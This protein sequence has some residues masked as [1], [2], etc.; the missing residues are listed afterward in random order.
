VEDDGPLLEFF[1]TI[2]RREGYEVLTAQNGL[3]ALEIAK[4]R[5]D[6]RIDILFSD[7]AM[8]YMGGVQLALNLRQIR[9]EIQVLLISAMPFQEIS[10][11]CGSDLQPEFL[12]KPFSVSELTAKIKMIVKAI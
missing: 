10:N 12:A 4:S 9:P 11:Q 2:L 8:P 3:V 5:P 7:V 6:E 1:S